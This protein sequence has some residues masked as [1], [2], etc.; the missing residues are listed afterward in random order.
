MQ[1]MA[2]T[3]EISVPDKLIEALGIDS[4]DFSHCAVEAVVAQSFRA[5]KITHA[6]V[7]E[8]LGFD[9]WQTDKFLKNERAFRPNEAEEFASDLVRLRNLAK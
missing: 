8:I 3:I 9:R 7:G 2:A 6:Q 1:C 5:G 4:A